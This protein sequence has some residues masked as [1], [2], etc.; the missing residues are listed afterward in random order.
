ML[1]GNVK[2][3]KELFFTAYG[4]PRPQGSK[5]HVGNGRLIEA[6]DVKPWRA[7]IT[8]AIFKAWMETGDERVFLEPVVVR[9]TFFLPRPKTV[10]RPLPSVAPD[11]DKLCRAL[12]D[13]LSVDSHAVQD[14]A[15]I[16]KWEASKVY[17]PDPRDAGVRVSVRLATPEDLSEAGETTFAFLEDSEICEHCGK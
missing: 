3:R 5:R 8:N 16:V 7:T 4:T 11:L 10:K 12:G 17:A 1:S 15:L 9:A 2:T 13:A 14:D 6:S